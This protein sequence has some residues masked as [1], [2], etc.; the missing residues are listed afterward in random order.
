MIK[1]KEIWQIFHIEGVGAQSKSCLHERGMPIYTTDESLYDTGY[2]WWLHSTICH[3]I[4]PQAQ[5]WGVCISQKSLVYWIC[6][7]QSL[8]GRHKCRLYKE[9]L[10]TSKEK[11]KNGTKEGR[12]CPKGTKKKKK[13]SIYIHVTKERMLYCLGQKTIVQHFVLKLWGFFHFFWS[14]LQSLSEYSK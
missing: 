10:R 7:C 8:L 6:C 9:H 5:Y 4:L 12:S 2:L 3:S 13:Y 11:K 14:I 1:E